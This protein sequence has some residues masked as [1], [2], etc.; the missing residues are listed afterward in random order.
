MDLPQDVDAAAL[1]AKLTTV[2]HALG[3]T[4]SLRAADSD[5]L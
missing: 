5:V 2:A 3:V 1:Q 4:A